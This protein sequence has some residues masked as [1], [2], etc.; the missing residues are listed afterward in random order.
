VAGE[1]VSDGT[2]DITER[3]IVYGTSADPTVDGPKMAVDGK[4]GTFLAVLTGLN[5]STLYHVRAY[6]VNVKG[7]AYGKDTVFTT[8]A[9]PLYPPTVET[10]SATDVQLTS[11]IVSGKIISNG[12][13]PITE[14]GFVYDTAAGPTVAA[15]KIIF[16][17]LTDLFSMTLS[18]LN[19][20]TK[21]FARAYAVNKEGTAYGDD[22]SFTTQTGIPDISAGQAAY[23]FG[24][25]EMDT[26]SAPFTLIVENKGTAVLNIGAIALSGTDAAQFAKQNDAC[27]NQ[28]LVPLETKTIQII[29]SPTASGDKAAVLT[30]PSNDPD[31]PSLAI[32]LTGKG[33]EEAI[34][35]GDINAS[36]D[37]TMA[38]VLLALKAGSG[39]AD[40]TVKIAADVND[41]KKIGVYEAIYD[42][43]GLGG[44]RQLKDMTLESSQFE[45]D[46]TLPEKY[47]EDGENVSPPLTWSNPPVGTQSFV[48]VME[49]PDSVP[50]W[51]HWIVYNIPA[52]TSS[53]Q[54]N[55]GASGGANLP[56]DAIHGINSFETGNNY[57]RGPS[58][59]EGSGPHKYI[60][61]LYALSVADLNPTAT[62]K[63]GIAAAMA[64]KILSQ[65][66]LTGIYARKAPFS[67]G[68]VTLKSR[69]WN[70]NDGLKFS[71]GAVVAVGECYPDCTTMDFYVET[72]IVFLGNHVLAQDLGEG[73]SLATTTQVPASGYNITSQDILYPQTGR[74][75]AFLLPDRTFG[76]IEFT[77]IAVADPTNGDITYCTVKYKYQPDGTTQF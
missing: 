13:T 28:A 18:S 48:L 68:S 31:T 20:G 6:A 8:L 42:I 14:R 76:M 69:N 25:V 34:L 71:T 26:A 73:T 63:N 22:L 4:L 52:S 70:D 66:S 37:I 53:F 29:F 49:D 67:E 30:I 27:S 3:G 75:F 51:D 32:Q 40:D 55:A 72:N 35:K 57:Y 11:A 2:A 65:V 7:V 23:D 36:G 33:L 46:Q 56:A 45:Q 1:V 16:T 39:K 21:Y 38:D 54:E 43:Q 77:Q 44:L 58:P 61:T 17:G 47:T 64:G 5:P 41:D 10:V 9:P 60:F 15:Q 50:L 59:P 62:T 24:N 74:V 12:G 19:Q